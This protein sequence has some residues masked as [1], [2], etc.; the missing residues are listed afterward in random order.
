MG[1]QQHPQKRG[2]E[3]MLQDIKIK[4]HNTM[5][6]GI[7]QWKVDK[8]GSIYCVKPESG[9]Y[10]ISIDRLTDS[11]AILDFIAQVSQKTWA[12]SKLIGDL[13]KLLDEVIGL[14]GSVCGN[15]VNKTLT[16]KDLEAIAKD[17]AEHGSGPSPHND[18][19]DGSNHVG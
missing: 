2:F 15:G 5:S 12:D 16:P 11:A 13:V 1:N 18:K 9:E 14:Q 4:H 6:N 17:C 3:T 19:T 7:G 8:A 10:W